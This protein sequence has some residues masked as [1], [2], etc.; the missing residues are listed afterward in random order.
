[1]TLHSDEPIHQAVESVYAASTE[2]DNWPAALK[3]LSSLFGACAMTLLHRH[4]RGGRFVSASA[5]MDPRLIELYDQ[6]YWQHDPTLSATDIWPVGRFS[7][8]AEAVTEGKYDSNEFVADLL[9][10]NDLYIVAGS[11]LVRSETAFASLGLHRPK[12]ALLKT[13]TNRQ[14]ELIRLVLSGLTGLV[15]GSNGR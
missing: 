11:V 8:S 5:H 10:P 3:H 6:Y 7:S 1:M 13:D 15:N 14:G 12:R 9:L 2:P 4:D